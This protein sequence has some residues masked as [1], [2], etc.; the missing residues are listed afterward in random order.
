MKRYLAIIPARG[1]SKRLPRKNIARVDGQPVITYPISS[2]LQS[3]L[4]YSIVVST[5]DVEIAEISRRAGATVIARPAALATDEAHEF[6]AC[7]HALDTLAEEHA[8]PFAFCIIYPT[9]ALLVGVGVSSALQIRRD[10]GW[11]PRSR[12]RD[13]RHGIPGPSLQGAEDVA[14][15]IS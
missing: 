6:A 1:G 14:E 15:R 3:G 10:A 13:G 5:E 8:D 2:A 11:S 12:C 9:A 4:F 7:A